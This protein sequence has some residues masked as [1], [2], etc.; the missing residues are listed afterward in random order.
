MSAQTVFEKLRQRVEPEHIKQR[1]QGGATLDYVE[2]HKVA[3]LLDERA[4][5]WACEIREVGHIG[6]KVF[7]KVAMTIAGV[8][9]ENIG[10]EDDEKSGYG[11]P[12]SNSF[13]MAFRRVAALFG[14]AR[15]LYSKD[16]KPGNVRTMPART[17][18]V[19]QVPY[20]NAAKPAPYSKAPHQEQDPNSVTGAQIGA[21][22]A[23]AL[24]TKNNPDAYKFE[25]MSKSEASQIIKGLQQ[26]ADSRA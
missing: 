11:D 8:T 18:H 7:I 14:L 25:T 4:P 12:F 17:E 13:S 10:Y 24:K 9:R 1:K 20:S 26:M 15:H 6:G 19:T 21:I 23:L 22:K 16:D 3:D 2:W 5:G